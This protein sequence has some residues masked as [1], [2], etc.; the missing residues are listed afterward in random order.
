MTAR[1]QFR[2]ATCAAS[3]H[4]W[5]PMCDEIDET[6]RERDRFRKHSMVLNAIAWRISEALG[7]VG[8][9]DTEVLG[10]V[11]SDLEELISQ[12]RS[13][14]R[15]T[16]PWL[17][18]TDCVHGIVRYTCGECI[19]WGPIVDTRACPQCGVPAGTECEPPGTRP[20]RRRYEPGA[21]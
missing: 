9:D 17:M 11:Q 5:G 1:D 18:D 2:P 10:D 16:A 8:A 20:H 3:L 15:M 7:K 4:M 6:R 13:V 12:T 21:T 14:H 19:P